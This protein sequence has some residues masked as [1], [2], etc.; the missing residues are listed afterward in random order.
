M[1]QNKLIFSFQNKISELEQENFQLKLENVRLTSK[2]KI[3]EQSQN[4]N[5]NNGNQFQNNPDL[6]KEHKLLLKDSKNLVIKMKKMDKEN[7]M[8]IQ[9]LVENQEI[10]KNIQQENM[11]L[12]VSLAE[13]TLELE[14]TKIDLE[15]AIKEQNRDKQPSQTFSRNEQT[16]HKILKMKNRMKLLM[17]ELTMNNEKLEK[18]QITRKLL[19]NCLLR[20]I[21]LADNR[22]NHL[23]QDIFHKV[24]EIEEKISHM[25]QII[26][27][28]PV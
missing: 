10:I 7:K 4:Q 6:C 20:T 2:I 28:N 24:D 16:K 12:K 9:Q 27:Q 5:Y 13:S 26:S 17:N 21:K 1:D 18:E 8:L 19:A 23:Q 11:D 25:S 15:K 22:L 14:S 3:L